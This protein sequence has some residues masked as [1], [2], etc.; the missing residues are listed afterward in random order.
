MPTL[1]MALFDW[2]DYED[3]KPADT[4]PSSRKKGVY[5]GV[6]GTVWCYEE[7]SSGEIWPVTIITA[8]DGFW[9]HGQLD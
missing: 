8:Q 3:M 4:W 1:D 6:T 7:G 9:V 5:S 2:T